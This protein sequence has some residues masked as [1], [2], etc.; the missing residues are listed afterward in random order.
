MKTILEFLKF[1]KY[2]RKLWLSPL[3]VVLILLGGI[4][5]IAEGSV[6]APFIYS[7]F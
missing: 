1:L 2:R 4:L 6:F 3:I 5:V 7:I